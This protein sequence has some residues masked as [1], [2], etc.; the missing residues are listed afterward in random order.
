MFKTPLDIRAV[1]GGYELRDKFV[2]V[3]DYYYITVPIG[4][5]TDFASIPWFFRRLIARDDKGIREA[6]VIHDWLYSA[7]SIRFNPY[8]T[9]KEADKIFLKIMRD[10]GAKRYKAYLAYYAVRMFG[11]KFYRKK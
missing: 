1:V 5:Y 3:D 10:M 6:S 4:F 11:G 7:K 2:Y 9:R 8:I